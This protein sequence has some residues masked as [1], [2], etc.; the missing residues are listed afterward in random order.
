MDPLGLP[1][2]ACPVCGTVLEDPTYCRACRMP[3]I[4]SL[5]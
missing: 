3:V 5:R 2:V 1:T 4:P